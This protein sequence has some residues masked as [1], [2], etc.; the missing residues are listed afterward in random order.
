MHALYLK[1]AGRDAIDAAGG[2]VARRAFA[3]EADSRGEPSYFRGRN[4]SGRPIP[5][6]L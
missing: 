1:R 2:G 5:Y 6:N 3:A 4:T